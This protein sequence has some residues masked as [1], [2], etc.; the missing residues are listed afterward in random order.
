MQII[1]FANG[2]DYAPQT[3]RCFKPIHASNKEEASRYHHFAGKESF[4]NHF[5]CKWWGC[6]PPTPPAVLKP[7]IF[8]KKGSIMSSPLFSMT[9]VLQIISFANGGGGLCSRIPP[10]FL[11]KNNEI[12][13]HQQVQYGKV[14]RLTQV[15]PDFFRV[16]IKPGT[17]VSR[18][19]I[20]NSAAIE[21]SMI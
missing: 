21:S 20:L 16:K 12:S 3:P 9:E 18:E 2:G 1:L 15:E 5:V 6:A 10:L 19:W 8:A 7:S 13:R 11:C 17:N 4:A 14:E